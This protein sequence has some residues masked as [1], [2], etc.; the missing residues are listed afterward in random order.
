MA[1]AKASAA[2]RAPPPRGWRPKVVVCDVDG[3]LTFKDRK[4]DA[5]ALEALRAVE[6]NGIPVVLATGN[7]LP[8][9]YALSYMIGTS[10]PIVAENG[11]LLYYRGEVTELSRRGAV[12]DVARDIEDILGLERLFTDR[13]RL[14]E[15]AFPEKPGTF[16]AVRAQ[17]ALH[18][19]GR[20][21]RVE[22]TG[23][24]V[25]LMQPTT[26]KFTGVKAALK[27]MGLTPGDALACGDSDNDT[28]MVALCRAGVALADAPAGLRA[29][30]TL[31]TKAVAGA[32]LKEGFAHYG[33]AQFTGAGRAARAKPRPARRR[34][35]KSAARTR[36]SSPAKRAKRAT[37]APKAARRR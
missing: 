20:E 8:I 26:E 21:V 6:A 34:P 25:H 9:A 31:V 37:R 14:T 2:L 23:F 24:A 22:R 28:E 33:V 27:A 35:P 19:Q 3:T 7:V 13:W 5:E 16:D 18:S 4:L 1:R 36:G 12:E 17:V 11:G 15:V 10:G 29:V 30:A 32:G